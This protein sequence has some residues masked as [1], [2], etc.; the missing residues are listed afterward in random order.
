[1]G[2]TL[3]RSSRSP[4]PSVRWRSLTA[5]PLPGSRH[6]VTSGAAEGIFR[7]HASP[8]LAVG[9]CSGPGHVDGKGHGTGQGQDPAA[10]PITGFRCTPGRDRWRD[11]ATPGWPA[12]GRPGSPAAA[13]GARGDVLGPDEVG[14]F[15]AEDKAQGRHAR[16]PGEIP[17]RGWW[18]VLRRVVREV[19]SDEVGMAAAS[20]GFYAMLS[21]FPAISVS[22]SL[23]GLVADPAAIEDQL[24]GLRD[25]LPASTYMMIAGRV[26]DLATAG[27]TKLSWGLALSLP[28]AL[29]SAMNGTKAI[30]RALNVAY[31]ERERRSFLRF[32][33]VALLFTLGGI[34]GVVLALTVIVL[35]PAALSFSWLGPLASIA[36]RVCSFGLLLGSVVLGVALLYRFGPSRANAKWRWI[37]S[38]SLVT[39]GLWLAASLA[40]SFYVSNFGSYDA[41]YGTLGGVV[42]ALLWFWISAYAVILGAELNAELELQTRRDTTTKPVRPM[43]ERGAFVADHVAE[44]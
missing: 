40:F 22:I 20:C 19:T 9:R 42:V 31:E 27:P 38:G 16:R 11:A 37:T 23:Y 7:W 30:I 39:A 26:H 18:A 36:V 35:V 14:R 24:A 33:L 17:P 29:W 21:L 32:N 5:E 3:F 15:S 43:G 4:E 10:P 6:A 8:A 25:V 1:M 2:V 44:G 28:V 41:A 13:G 34:L 12:P